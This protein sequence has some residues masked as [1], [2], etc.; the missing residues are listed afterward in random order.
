MVGKQEVIWCQ[1]TAISNDKSACVELFKVLSPLSR[2]TR[3]PQ[4]WIARVLMVET[5]TQTEAGKLGS[6]STPRQVK[7]RSCAN[8]SYK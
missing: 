7:W 1:L 2:I 4:K 6:Q 5:R 8:H 3:F